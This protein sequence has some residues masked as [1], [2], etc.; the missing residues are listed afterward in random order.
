MDTLRAYYETVVPFQEYLESV[1]ALHGINRQSVDACLTE[2]TDSQE[3]KDLI[4][5]S[6][7]GLR[8]GQGHNPP[9]PSKEVMMPQRAVS[10]RLQHDYMMAPMT[11]LMCNI[12]NQQY[13]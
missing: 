12:V 2:P 8:K 9:R 13:R 6:V 4:R 5:M 3:Y 1:F 11:I 7:V 10:I